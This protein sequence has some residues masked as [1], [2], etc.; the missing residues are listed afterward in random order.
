MV[1]IK[2]VFK[3]DFF[4]VN[5]DKRINNPLDFSNYTLDLSKI[6][7]DLVIKADI[8]KT[9]RPIDYLKKR[10][11]FENT[12]IVSN[13]V[14]DIIEL[15]TNELEYKGIFVTE[16]NFKS[17]FVYWKLDL[18][19]ATTIVLDKAEELQDNVIELDEVRN[20]MMFKVIHIK[21]DYLI[22]RED[23]VESILKRSSLGIKF[24]KICVQ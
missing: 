8:L 19:K 4:I 23:I 13:K 20:L 18:S 1:K 3:I 15:H 21:Q 24:Q 6:D 10:F 22:L 2:A 16:K 17:L 11:L 14:K 12:Y 9:S 7:D 5:E